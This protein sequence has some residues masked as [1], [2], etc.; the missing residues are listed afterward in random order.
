[1]GAANGYR[2][3]FWLSLAQY[4]GLVAGVVAGAAAAD[5][6]LGALGISGSGARPLAAALVLVVGGS[7]GSSVGF[8]LGGPLRNAIADRR[9]RG[10]PEM[11]AGAVFSAAGMLSVVWF[12]GLT[13]DRGPSQA[14]ARQVQGSAVLA[15]L[16]LFFPRPPPWLAGVEKTL[17]GVPFPQTFAD[18]QPN[19]PAPLQPPASVDTAEVRGA[20][21]SVFRVAG[22]GCGGE[23]SGSA[24]PVARGYL[25]TNAH[26]V[27]GT[28]GTV[29]SQGPPGRRSGGLAASVVLFDPDRD[30]AVL[31]VPGLT[32][33]ALPPAAAARGTQGAVIGYPGG[34]PEDLEPAVVDTQ[35]SARGRDI[36]NDR[37]VTRQILVMESLVRPGNSGGPLIDLQGQVLGL[38][39][40]ASSSNSNQAYA[41]TN[42]EIAADVRSGVATTRPVAV[43]PTCAV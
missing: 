16:D 24:Y 28:S 25:V 32:V 35:T 9:E 40:A 37:L 38:V 10:G 19:L 43:P 23:V 42:A 6:V 4:T 33:P 15:R 30:V 2:R 1:M 34:G 11:L 20:A 8:W 41:L 29:V 5:P 26:V 18:L 39:F 31:Y 27:A 13:F 36:Y 3:G 21:G 14:L 7:L 22:R 17:A 12:L